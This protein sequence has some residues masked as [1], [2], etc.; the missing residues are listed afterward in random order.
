MPWLVTN[1]R[2][3]SLELN[4]ISLHSMIIVSMTLTWSIFDTPDPTPRQFCLLWPD[5]KP[6]P[7][8]LLPGELLVSNTH[9]SGYECILVITSVWYTSSDSSLDIL[10]YLILIF[11]ARYGIFS[12]RGTTVNCMLKIDIEF[13]HKAILYFTLAGGRLSQ[14]TLV[15]S[16]RQ[17][18]SRLQSISSVLSDK[19]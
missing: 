3:A 14:V 7:V 15:Q 13:H 6:N 5:A 19:V 16:F 11:Q 2:A 8:S 12:I 17:E 9:V 10:C 1:H 4:W 18:V